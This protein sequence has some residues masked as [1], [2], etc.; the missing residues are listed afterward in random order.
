MRNL[1]APGRS[2]V[3]ATGAMASTSHPLATHAALD[4]LKRG[5]NA[6]DAAIA[7]CATQCVVEPQS[8]GI[9]G[10]CF[11]LYSKQGSPDI[12]AFN[13]SGRT[14]AAATADW[15]DERGI[16]SIERQSPHA[17]T[18]PGAVN[19]WCQLNNDHGALPLE[20]L[21]QSAIHYAK[22]GYPITSRVSVD[23]ARQ[24]DL[25]KRNEAAAAVFLAEGKTPTF[26]SMH[27]QPALAATLEAIA[28]SGED[29]FYRGAIA[30][31]LVDTLQ[32]LG[33]L[34]TADDFAAAAGE[35]VDPIKSHYKGYDIFQVPPNGQGVI[36]LQLLNIVNGFAVNEPLS[37]ERLHLE[38]EAGRQAYRDRYLYVADQRH[39][40]VPVDWLLSVAHADEIRQ[41]IDPA[42][43]L[44]T[45]PQYTPP[46]HRSTVYITVVDKDRNACSFINSLFDSF[47]SVQ[48]AAKSGVMFHNRGQGFVVDRT[49]PNGIDGGKRPLHTIIPGMAAKDGKVV[50]P[51]G[52]MG[53]E[54]QS[55]GHMQF[56]TRYLDFGMDIQ[57]AQDAPRLFPTPGVDEVEYESTFD[58]KTIKALASLG[59]NMVPA[60]RPI[61]GSQAIHIDWQTGVLT[62]GSDP[63]KD[64][65]ALGY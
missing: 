48:M 20:A 24:I 61:G 65:C 47:G 60:S 34:H 52:V 19:A 28:K 54:Y 55:Y 16:K 63:R 57:E 27:R 30:A 53:G 46:G 62:G 4:V 39:A 41:S 36:A 35:Y 42:Q 7:A 44:T 18:V 38:I 43:R 5:G 37:A 6:L 59:H 13:G 51:Y 23:C 64:G 32:S 26:G 33:G 17:V 25:L 31:D 3:L 10:D 22:N 21:L 49:H 12:I 9:G 50:L 14:P 45:L 29:V 8:T 2:P 1:E 15:F 58:N 56:L 11:C 40:D